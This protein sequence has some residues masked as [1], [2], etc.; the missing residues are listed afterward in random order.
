[1]VGHVDGQNRDRRHALTKQARQYVEKLLAGW[2]LLWRRGLFAEMLV[3]CWCKRLGNGAGNVGNGYNQCCWRDWIPNVITECTYLSPLLAEND[4]QCLPK[5]LLSQQMP[6]IPMMS[7]TLSHWWSLFF[8][9]SRQSPIALII[10][11]SQ[12]TL[13]KVNCSVLVRDQR[14]QI[15]KQELPQGQIWPVIKFA[16]TSFQFTVLSKEATAFLTAVISPDVEWRMKDV[17]CRM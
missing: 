12:A 13:W 4:C 8:L 2:G 11:N 14:N 17:G 3:G 16:S 15:N 10:C 6:L 5:S 7:S 9:T 1:M